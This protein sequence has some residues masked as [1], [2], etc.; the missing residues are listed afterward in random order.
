MAMEQRARGLR[1]EHKS[2]RD[3]VTETDRAI[4]VKLRDRIAERYPEHIVFGEEMGQE[5]EGSQ[6]WII[7]PIDGTGSFVHGQ[8]H[9][10]VSI[11][12][13]EKGELQWAAVY[14]P[15]FDELFMAQRGGGA[16]LNGE[17]IEVSA[18]Q[19]LDEAVLGTGFACLRSQLPHN[20]LPYLNALLP[21]LQDLRRFGSAAL[22][23]A[24]VACGRLDGFWE[25]NL[26]LYDVAAGQLIVEEA[27]GRVSDFDGS[28]K[29]IPDRYLASN[30]VLHE[31]IRQVLASVH[32][33]QEL[34]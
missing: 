25:L 6:R 17:G 5:G 21:Q 27:G 33:D 26:N 4:E 16:E 31:D 23:L 12:Y 22:D 14:A 18:C 29:G 2:R 11:A 15:V 1:V 7:D 9:F 20:N 30:T 24:Y 32:G 8:P 28:K 34:P 3:L 13:E 10:S 19:R